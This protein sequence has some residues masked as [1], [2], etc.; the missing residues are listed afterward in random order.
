M[1]DLLGRAGRLDEAEDLIIG[2]LIKP[3]V[4]VW[5]CLLSACRI[6]NKLHLAKRV[7]EHIFELDP[8]KTTP[9]VLLSNMYATLGR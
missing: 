3:D 1:F 4:V 9:Y 8:E 7:A 2:M 6:H 5:I